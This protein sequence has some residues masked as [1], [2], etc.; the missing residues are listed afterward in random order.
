MKR[1]AVGSWK[2]KIQNH[3]FIKSGVFIF[4]TMFKFSVA[5]YNCSG[6]IELCFLIEKAVV[7]QFYSIYPTGVGMIQQ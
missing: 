1:M 4:F 3:N 2:K 5:S 6:H 7:M